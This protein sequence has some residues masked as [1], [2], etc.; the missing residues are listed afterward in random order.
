M[1]RVPHKRLLVA[2]TEAEQLEALVG[3][4]CGLA[5]G[6]RHLDLTILHVVVIPRSLPLEA[7]MAAEVAEGETLLA[8]AEEVAEALGGRHMRTDLLQAREAGPAILQEIHERAIEAVVLGARRG[9]A[10]GEH[11]MGPTVEYLIKHAPC[12]VVIAVPP[13]PLT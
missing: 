7:E 1:A 13:A 10:F 11:A 8:K 12:R 4:A 3:L 6:P 5:G 9:R 2:I